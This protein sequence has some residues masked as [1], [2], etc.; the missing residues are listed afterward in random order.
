MSTTTNAQAEKV[1]A[2]QWL[3]AARAQHQLEEQR[4]SM[5]ECMDRMNSFMEIRDAHLG[6]ITALGFDD[7]QAH[8]ALFKFYPDVIE[9]FDTALLERTEDDG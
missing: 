1:V 2:D 3:D 4:K 6:V 5:Q 9:G 8:T 7:T